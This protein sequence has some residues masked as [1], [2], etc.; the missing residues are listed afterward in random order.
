MGNVIKSTI[1]DIKK[2]VQTVANVGKDVVKE[3]AGI[4]SKATHAVATVG[5]EA[6]HVV[7]LVDPNSKLAKGLA[8]V[9]TIANMVG[10]GVNDVESLSL[11][12]I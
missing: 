11:I 5:G 9:S 12:H 10:K 2:G 8:S 1:K 7:S 6:A 4:L 3:G